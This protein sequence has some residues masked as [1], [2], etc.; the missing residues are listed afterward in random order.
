VGRN[1]SSGEEALPERGRDVARWYDEYHLRLL[2]YL[3]ANLQKEHDAEDVSQE[4]YL[5]LL[6][7][8]EERVVEHPRAYLLRVAA[9]VIADWR[10]G[11]RPY[12]SRPLEEL[13][14]PAEGEDGAE[15]YDRQRRAERIERALAAL[16]A[17]YRA[18]VVLKTRH[19]LS[20]GEIAAHLG[21]SE[22]RV[23]RYI[24]KAYARLRDR[25]NANER[26]AR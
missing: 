25:L 7:I 24:V 19:G 6:R 14:Q 22:R 23:K 3:R 16:P 9:N 17:H 1:G 5:R 26:A 21:V 15:S 8:P 10:A 2:G 11:Q 13:D 20:Y 4:V 18:A 12:E